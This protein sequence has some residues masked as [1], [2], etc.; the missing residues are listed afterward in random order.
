MAEENNEEKKWKERLRDN[1]RLVIMNHETFE[2]VGSYKLSLLNVYVIASSVIV[3]VALLVVGLIIFTPVKR[4]IPGY[5]DV[6]EHAELMRIN[7][8]MQMMEE[9]LVAQKAYTDNFRRILVGN[10]EDSELEEE[11][12]NTVLPDSL[13]SVERIEEDEMLRQVIEDEE[14]SQE[15]ELLTKTANFTPREV[16]L[17]QL[18]FI[19]PVSGVVSA[20]YQPDIQHYGIDVLAPKNTPVKAAMDG[21]VFMSDWT[22]ET[23][24][25]IG[26]QHAHN[27]ISFYKH[28]SALLKQRGDFVNSGEALAIIGNTGT[29][30]SGPHL[31]FELWNNGKPVNPDLYINFE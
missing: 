4:Y 8:Q 10:M 19:P 7:E 11:L 26:V 17:E 18:Y 5:G 14:L 16:P 20:A 22:L 15:K 28:N 29:L 1:Y 23:G 31:H 27:L 6:K 24:H 12:D 13:L 30:S 9:Q 21:Y 3:L 25:T 2:E